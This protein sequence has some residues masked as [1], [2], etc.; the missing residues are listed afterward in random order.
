M[1]LSVGVL[2]LD[3]SSPEPGQGGRRQ[4]VNLKA[5]GLG[6]FVR[7]PRRGLE[8]FHLDFELSHLRQTSRSI[9]RLL[10]Y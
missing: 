5:Q 8:N 7:R 2:P 1:V 4:G 9:S 10:G 6:L 3:L